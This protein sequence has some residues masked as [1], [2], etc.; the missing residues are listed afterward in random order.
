MYLVTMMMMMNKNFNWVKS[1][2]NTTAHKILVFRYLFIFCVK[3]L[4]RAA[5]HD[6]SKYGIYES[7]RLA[8][9]INDLNNTVYG[10]DK[11][12]NNLALLDEFRK[13][14]YE[15]NTHHPEYYEFGFRSMS[16]LDRIEMTA[17]WL[18]SSRRNK[19]G[20]I[21]RSISLNRKRFSYSQ[22][23]EKWIRKLIKDFYALD[24]KINKNK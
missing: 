1:Q 16:V 13:H 22:D 17:D 7:T 23:D 11:Y 3:L 21:S 12:N 15:R 10:S 2:Y 8:R 5:V 24:H 9:V 4:Y 18:A 6:F 14:H 19:S 20:N